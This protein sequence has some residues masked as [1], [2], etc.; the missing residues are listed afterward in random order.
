MV[1][2]CVFPNP[3]WQVIN[4][5]AMPYARSCGVESP[6]HIQSSWAYGYEIFANCGRFCFSEQRNNNFC[7]DALRWTSRDFGTGSHHD[8]QHSYLPIKSSILYIH[9]PVPCERGHFPPLRQAVDP[10]C[11]P[12]QA[13]IIWW[14]RAAS[15]LLSTSR[16][17]LFTSDRDMI[18][19][20]ARK[21]SVGWNSTNLIASSAL[22]QCATNDEAGELQK[23]INLSP[24]SL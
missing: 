24:I 14:P 5:S 7:L 10:T 3:M 9:R 13:N 18:S 6:V 8:S 21:V 17:Q 22:E 16:G 11:M 2:L 19:L 12:S 15:T 20:I 1:F 4:S 23:S